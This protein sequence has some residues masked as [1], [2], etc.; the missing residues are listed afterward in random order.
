MFKNPNLAEIFTNLAENPKK[1]ERRGGGGVCF[2]QV[3]W[4]LYPTNMWQLYPTSV[5][6]LFQTKFD[7]YIYQLC[8]S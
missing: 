4:Q 1:I 6:Q 3:W 8:G 2:F 7:G 5:W